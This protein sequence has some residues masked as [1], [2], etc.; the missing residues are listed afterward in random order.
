MG[1]S[2]VHPLPELLVKIAVFGN[3]QAV[4][5]ADCLNLLNPKIRAEPFSALEARTPAVAQDFAARM[6]DYDLVVSQRVMAKKYGAMGTSELIGAGSRVI[7]FPTL[8]FTGFHPDCLVLEGVGAGRLGSYHSIII[9]GAYLAGVPQQRVARLFNSYVFASLGYMDEYAR[10]KAFLLGHI[11]KTELGGEALFARW[12]RLGQF[13]YTPN[14]PVI[15]ALRELAVDLCGRIGLQA[16]LTAP[17][18]QDAL[19]QNLRLPVYPELARRLG[20]P[21]ARETALLGGEVLGLE[22]L[23]AEMYRRYDACSPELA[24]NS[25]IAACAELFRAELDCVAA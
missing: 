22:E 18:P 2:W 13:M 24:G 11:A 14:H 6:A 1:R 16:D 9:A 20:V 10:A 25:R 23:V 3:C 5:L 7:L 15:G 17:A 21:G 19:A 4:G 8:T 12:E